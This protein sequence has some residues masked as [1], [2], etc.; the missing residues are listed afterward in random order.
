MT[1][2]TFFFKCLYLSIKGKLDQCYETR[3]IFF[4]TLGKSQACFPSESY[5]KDIHSTN[6]S[7]NFNELIYIYLYFVKSNLDIFN[8]LVVKTK[9][10]LSVLSMQVLCVPFKIITNRVTGSDATPFWPILL[11]YFLFSLHCLSGYVR[12]PFN[13][14]FFA[15]LKTHEN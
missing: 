5:K 3:N 1:L 10:K 7:F 14:V 8:S 6:N 11:R 2:Q 15:K 4:W 12:D 13:F 9:T